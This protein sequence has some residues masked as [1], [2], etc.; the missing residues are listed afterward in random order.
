MNNKDAIDAFNAALHSDERMKRPTPRELSEIHQAKRKSFVRHARKQ[1]PK[2]EKAD[3][4]EFTPK[5]EPY[6]LTR[7]NAKDKWP[8][9][10]VRSIDSHI[11]IRANFKDLKQANAFA[12][13]VNKLYD[14]AK[15]G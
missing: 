15:R 8:F 9:H 7:S 14:A 1:L 3:N 13:V 5:F 4:R 2:P 10:Y 11:T 6:V 12:R